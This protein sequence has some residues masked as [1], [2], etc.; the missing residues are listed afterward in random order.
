MNDK[1]KYCLCTEAT[2]ITFPYF[3]VMLISFLKHNSGWSKGK[4]VILT[5]DLTPLSK[6]NRKIIK[7]ISSLVE[8]L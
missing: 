3:R 6:A 5:C 1:L 8:R 7:E 2:D 4:L